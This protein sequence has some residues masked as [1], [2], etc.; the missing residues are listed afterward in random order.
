MVRIGTCPILNNQAD[1]MFLWSK[2]QSTLLI[3]NISDTTRR[4]AMHRVMESE[5]P[6]SPF[7]I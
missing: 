5:R 7:C 6:D 2:S 4:V 3:E 1:T